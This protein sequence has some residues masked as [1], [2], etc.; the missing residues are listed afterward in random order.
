MLPQ[1]LFDSIPLNNGGVQ[2]EEEVEVEGML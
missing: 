2:D 1:F